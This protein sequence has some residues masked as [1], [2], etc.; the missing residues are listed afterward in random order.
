MDDLQSWKE[1]KAKETIGQ[2]LIYTIL[3]FAGYKIYKFGIEN[4]VEDMKKEITGNYTSDTNSRIMSTLDYVVV[5]PETKDAV[6]VE[7]KYR[8]LK[9]GDGRGV[10]LIFKYRTINNHMTYWKDMILI[11]VF[12]V[13]PY[14]TCIRVQDIEWNYHLSGIVFRGTNKTD[15]LWNFCGIERD[16]QQ[17]FPRIHPEHIH[18]AKELLKFE[19]H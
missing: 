15:E 18:K 16:I 10:N 14:I 13:H 7:I 1:S 4:F 11:I 17:Y 5:D 6:L 9:E 3:D 8:G 12:N 2:N 19:E